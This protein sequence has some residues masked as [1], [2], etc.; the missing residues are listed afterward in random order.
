MPAETPKQRRFF[1]VVRGVQT[2]SVRN[3]SPEARKVASTMS[4][5]DV[6]DFARLPSRGNKSR[7]RSRSRK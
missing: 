2:G 6:R 3:A 7:I 1:G 4:V 5:S